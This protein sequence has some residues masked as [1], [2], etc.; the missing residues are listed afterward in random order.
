MPTLNDDT[1]AMTKGDCVGL[2]TFYTTT[3]DGLGD[4][5]YATKIDVIT[6][7]GESASRDVFKAASSLGAT[8]APFDAPPANLCSRADDPD[9]PVETSSTITMTPTVTSPGTVTSTAAVETP[10][11]RD[12]LGNYTL[13]GCNTE[14]TIAGIRALS[15]ASYV[16][17][18]MTLESCMTNCTGFYYWATEFGDECKIISRESYRRELYALC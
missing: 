18:G 8:C 2:Y 4:L 15:G 7:T 9:P 6:G 16:Y 3:Y 12:T 5:D 13:V 14:P 11:H 10:F 17:E 1:V